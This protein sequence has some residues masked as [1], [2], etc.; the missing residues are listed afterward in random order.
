MRA[1]GKP[2]T[3]IIKGQR[4]KLERGQLIESTESLAEKFGWSRGKVNRFLKLLKEEGM[5]NYFGT[6]NGTA[7]SIENYSFYQD[8][9]TADGTADG[10]ANGTTDG[11]QSKK[12]KKDKKDN[13]PP[14][15][16]Q[17]GARGGRSR[18]KP[19]NEYL[20]MLEEELR[21]NG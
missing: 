7:I 4:V 11:T 5:I 8:R 15:S 14:I 17:R 20:T 13:N 6:A 21:K 18:K 12:D 10:T 2:E 16:P 3:T 19:R 9:R 1:Q